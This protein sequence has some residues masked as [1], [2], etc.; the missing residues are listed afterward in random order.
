MGCA[1]GP[2]REVKKETRTHSLNGREGTAFSRAAMTIKNA[3][4]YNTTV[5][6]RTTSSVWRWVSVFMKMRFR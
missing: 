3:A 4:V 1:Q 2:G 5:S 6:M